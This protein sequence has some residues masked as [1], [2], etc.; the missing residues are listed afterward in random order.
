MSAFVEM[1]PRL[2][3]LKKAGDFVVK[4]VLLKK[5]KKRQWI[6]FDYLSHT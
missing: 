5:L 6:N 2:K 1:D 4:E 3:L